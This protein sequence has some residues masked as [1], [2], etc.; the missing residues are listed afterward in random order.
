MVMYMK[1]KLKP[2]AEELCPERYA[3]LA[4]ANARFITVKK[5]NKSPN[6][7]MRK[8]WRCF[9][10]Y[11]E[12]AGYKIIQP[13]QEDINKKKGNTLCQEKRKDTGSSTAL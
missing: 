9:K 11:L 8:F 3:Y 13:K 10:R 2:V 12:N 5:L 1:K 4:L 6:E 7:K